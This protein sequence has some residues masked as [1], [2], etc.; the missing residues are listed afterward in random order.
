MALL[1]FEV[2]LE[3]DSAEVRG[4][5]LYNGVEC[6]RSVSIV[7]PLSGGVAQKLHVSCRVVFDFLI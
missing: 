4:V 7:E 5:L 2:G 3:L 6:G 1:E